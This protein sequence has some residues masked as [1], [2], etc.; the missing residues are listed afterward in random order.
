MKAVSFLREH[1]LED[2]NFMCCI[3]RYRFTPYWK[4]KNRPFNEVSHRRNEE[5][6][7]HDYAPLHEAIVRLVEKAD[8]KVLLCQEDQS[9]MEIGKEMIY[10]KLPSH[11][12]DRV[13]WRESYWLTDEALSIYTHSA[14]LFGLEMHSPIMCIGN[15][16]PAIVCRIKE[17]TTKGF[18]WEDI[19]LGDW[20]FD[21]DKPDQV[22]NLN[23]AV[24]KIAQQ[25]DW[26]K[27]RVSK[28][29]AIV[30]ARQKVMCQALFQRFGW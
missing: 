7:E 19:G 1:H 15:G 13:V 2:K 22:K 18:M 21:M 11:V 14:G 8:M 10:D 24:L 12:V 29:H 27:E 28:A 3:P 26:A 6:K 20:L 9:Q 25:P 16:V 5:M 4:I 23:D 30:R 17:Q